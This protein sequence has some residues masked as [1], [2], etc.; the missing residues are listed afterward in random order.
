[1][2]SLANHKG[3]QYIGVYCAASNKYAFV[4]RGADRTLIDTIKRA[5]RVEVI[6]ITIGGS[7]IIGALMALNSN[8]VV[9]SSLA[10]EEDIAEIPDDLEVAIIEERYNAAGNNILVSDKAAMLHPGASAETAEE[11]SDVLGVEV[12]RS[13]IANIPTVGSVA[14]ATSK[15]VVCH[16]RASQKDIERL[17]EVFSVPV[18]LATLNYGTPWLGAC[19][20]ANDKGAVVGDKSTPIE[21]GK[22]EDG[23]GL[24]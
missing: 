18:T 17:K 3:N 4:P 12:V 9:L 22:I 2:I 20:I 16:P 6:E 21:I 1:M 13:T 8:G 7:P 19:A 24:I 10:T 15:G 11:L 5:L 14:L 23:L